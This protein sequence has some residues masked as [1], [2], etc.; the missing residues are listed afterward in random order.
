V[1]QVVVHGTKYSIRRVRLDGRGYARAR[2][3]C[4]AACSAESRDDD[5]VHTR[6]GWEL[7]WSASFMSRDA[8]AA[9][10]WC[11]PT[12]AGWRIRASPPMDAALCATG[13]HTPGIHRTAKTISSRVSSAALGTADRV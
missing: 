3:I 7:S 5:C 4:G 1:S 11:E 9:R 8:G 10:S 6:A 13:D 2:R 12:S